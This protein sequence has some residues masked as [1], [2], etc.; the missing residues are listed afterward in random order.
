LIKTHKAS[1]IEE[2]GDVAYLLGWDIEPLKEKAKQENLFLELTDKEKQIIEILRIEGHVSVERLS[3]NCSIPV[4]RISGILL[5]LELAGMIR[6]LP[7]DI[8]YTDA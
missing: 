6:C 8:Y 2:A 1:L 4:S 7:G 5:N 3:L